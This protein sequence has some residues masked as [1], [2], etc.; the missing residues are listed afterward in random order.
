MVNTSG[1][2]INGFT[3]YT[4][5]EGLTPLYTFSNSGPNFTTFIGA[6]TGSTEFLAGSLPGYSFTGVNAG[7]S[8]DF[9]R[10]ARG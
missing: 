1:A 3:P 9:S 7:N 10:S 8:I 5:T 4:A 6:A 2:T